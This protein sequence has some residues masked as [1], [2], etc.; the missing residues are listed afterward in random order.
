[1]KRSREHKSSSQDS[2]AGQSKARENGE[3]HLL[4]YL[5]VSDWSQHGSI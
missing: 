4:V 5:A 1:M 3:P 2:R